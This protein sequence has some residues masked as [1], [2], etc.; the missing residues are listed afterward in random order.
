MSTEGLFNVSII[1]VLSAVA[2]EVST[3][4]MLDTVRFKLVTK[5]TERY[6]RCVA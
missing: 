6:T 4:Y 1:V 5:P 2:A 3:P